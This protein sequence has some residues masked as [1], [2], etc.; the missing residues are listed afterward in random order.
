M[1]EQQI[2]ILTQQFFNALTLGGIYALIALGYTMVYGIIELINFAHGDIFTV[3]A[4]FG[5]TFLGWLGFSGA[6][7]D[8][9]TFAWVLAAVF[10]FVMPTL[11][12]VGVAIERFAYRPLR[13][14]P[15]LAPLLTAIGV[16][17]ILEN[18]LYIWRG[19]SPQQFPQLLSAQVR[20]N[21][22]GASVS[23]L[24]VLIFLITLVLLVALQLFVSR[25]RMGRAMRSTA[26]DREAAQ[27]M[28]VNIN[29][30]IAVTFFLGSALAGAAGIVY[31]LYFG[32]IAFNT[33]FSAGLKAFTAAVLGGI[34]NITGAVLGGFIIG[35]I[36]VLSAQLSIS[37][38]S[39]ALVFG[40][41]IIVLV[42]R[43]SG[44]L[45]TPIGERA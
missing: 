40:V 33:G 36:E 19:P 9:F 44:L 1:T 24:S 17:F 21:I 18:A 34:G 13:N 42:F 11:G 31:G 4:F 10:L 27:L 35:F 15:R 41:L 29:T 22:L 3:G 30:T 20:F 12:L 25:T 14:A 39:E 32:T 23:W 45:G 7:T 26:Q 2:A 43:P 6:I 16:S 38:W 37:R 5:L 8:P 28:G